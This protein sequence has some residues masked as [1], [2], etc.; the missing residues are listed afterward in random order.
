MMHITYWFNAYSIIRT[1][2]FST[3]L[4]EIFPGSEDFVFNSIS[5]TISILDQSVK[6]FSKVPPKEMLGK[7]KV[8]ADC[9]V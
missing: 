7:S 2:Y 4:E 1:V 6:L 5:P 9:R 3:A 8:R